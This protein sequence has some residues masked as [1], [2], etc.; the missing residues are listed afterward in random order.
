MRVLDELD[1]AFEKI[2]ALEKKERE[3]EISKLRSNI[4]KSYV[5]N[6]AMV[7]LVYIALRKK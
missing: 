1:V 6:T 4:A 3:A 5:I 7:V 2:D